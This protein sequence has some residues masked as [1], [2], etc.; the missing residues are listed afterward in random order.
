M[1]F[2]FRS[3]FRTKIEQERISTKIERFC[4]VVICSELLDIMLLRASVFLRLLASGSG[5]LLPR[6][7]CLEYRV[8]GTDRRHRDVEVRIRA[9]PATANVV[10]SLSLVATLLLEGLN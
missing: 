8:V 10:D 4:R 3:F 5:R 9:C 6:S 7:I 2:Y 1:S